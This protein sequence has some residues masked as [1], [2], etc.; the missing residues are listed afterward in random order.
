M[1]NIK[2]VKGYEG[3]YLVADDGTVYSLPRVVFNGRGFYERPM[4]K[5]RAGTRAGKYK[6]VILRKDGE[7]KHFAVHRL[8]AEAFLENPNHYEEVNHKDENPENNAV[9]NLEWCTRQYNIDYS[10]SKSVA[11][12]EN[13]LKI[14]EYKS[15]SYAAR[16][17]G[18]KR[19][20]I[21]NAVNGRSRTAGGYCWKYIEGSNE[22][23]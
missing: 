13:G 3:L 20:A 8:V 16:I 17:T 4:Q 22:K 2:P 5:L 19:T 6:F 14:A 9:S 12:F 10:K 11:Q 23:C 1:D 18:I 15:V 21:D 7:E